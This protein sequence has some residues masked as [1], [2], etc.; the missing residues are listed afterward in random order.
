MS[1]LTQLNQTSHARDWEL[2]QPQQCPTRLALSQS[3]KPFS[4]K[5][6]S[7]LCPN[8][9][10][11]SWSPHGDVSIDAHLPTVA[12]AAHRKRANCFDVRQK[13]LSEIHHKKKTCI[14]PLCSCTPFKDGKPTYPP[15]QR[16]RACLR[17]LR[18]PFTSRNDGVQFVRFTSK[19]KQNKKKIKAH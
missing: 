3:R 16:V 12:A 17:V 19:T 8:S 7:A 18:A 5:P 11:P 1:A 13:Q 10:A 9:V 6:P 2:F 4:E 14:A 15:P